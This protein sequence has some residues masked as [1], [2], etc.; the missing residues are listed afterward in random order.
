MK[1][2]VSQQELE[3]LLKEHPT[4]IPNWLVMASIAYYMFDETLI[5]DSTYDKLVRVFVDNKQ[6]FVNHRYYGLL[7]HLNPHFTSMYCVKP[8]DYPMGMVR[9]VHGLIQG[10]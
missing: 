9:H 6:H 4:A 3:A 10:K 1:L 5:E 8:T 7:E 2:P